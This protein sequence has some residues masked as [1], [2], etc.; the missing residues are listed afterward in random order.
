MSSRTGEGPEM[1]L[2][3]IALKRAFSLDM[4]LLPLVCSISAAFLVSSCLLQQGY[5]YCV[6]FPALLY[7]GKH[8]ILP[9]MSSQYLKDNVQL[10]TLLMSGVNVSK[11]IDA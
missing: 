5:D 4:V 10:Q 9:G 3:P 11:S 6:F 1:L 7:Q 2:L 8:L